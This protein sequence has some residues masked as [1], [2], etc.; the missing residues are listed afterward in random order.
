MFCF[1]LWFRRTFLKF[2]L[3]FLFTVKISGSRWQLLN[4]GC[5]YITKILMLL[6]SHPL[7]MAHHSKIFIRAI[8]SKFMNSFPLQFASTFYKLNCFGHMM[9]M[10][11]T[12]IYLNIVE[13]LTRLN[14]SVYNIIECYNKRN[15]SNLLWVF[16]QIIL[17][18][19]YV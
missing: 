2:L 6:F 10:L 17:F 15:T 3:K 16:Y 19:E 5:Q 12:G 13:H 9:Y 1:P 7:K 18:I 4:E 11:Q 14:R 8:G